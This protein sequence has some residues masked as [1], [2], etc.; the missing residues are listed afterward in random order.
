MP[1]TVGISFFKSSPKGELSY[2]AKKGSEVLINRASEPFHPL[3]ELPTKQ[4]I[5]TVMVDICFQ[6]QASFR[7]FLLIIFSFQFFRYHLGIT[8]EYQ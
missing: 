1:T 2:K 6:K 4:L 7:L 3:F 5:S 8:N